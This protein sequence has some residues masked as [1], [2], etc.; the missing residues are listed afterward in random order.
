MIE[1]ISIHQLKTPIQG[2]A[3]PFIAGIKFKQGAYLVIGL[4]EYLKRGSFPQNAY[5]I[6]AESLLD[7]SNRKQKER[8]G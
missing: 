3:D 4:E 1:V 8:A 7:F 5:T 2:I 6:K